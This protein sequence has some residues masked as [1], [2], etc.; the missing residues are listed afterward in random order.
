MSFIVSRVLTCGIGKKSKSLQITSRDTI[1][2]RYNVIVDT[3]TLKSSQYV[4]ISLAILVL[5]LAISPMNVYGAKN[6]AESM[7]GS[8]KY[9]FDWNYMLIFGDEPEDLQIKKNSH[10]HSD[11]VSSKKN[12]K[13][14]AVVYTCCGDYG[15]LS[16]SIGDKVKVTNDGKV[17]VSKE[18]KFKQIGGCDDEGCIQ[19]W[20]LPNVKKGTYNLVYFVR[21][22]TEV[23]EL[24]VTKIKVS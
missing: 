12:S 3:V 11:K 14:G 7:V 19:N 8:K 13:I 4:V 20:Q 24:Y 17:H 9:K 10:P 16:V 2:I 21:G 1:V 6:H 22:E 18:H 5:T 15:S 23:N